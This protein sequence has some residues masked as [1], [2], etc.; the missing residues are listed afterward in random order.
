MTPAAAQ[1]A[2]ADILVIGRAITE[3]TNAGDA[4]RA[5]MAD[6]NSSASSSQNGDA[7]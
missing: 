1:Q 5:I 6:L 4:A 2:G 7:S 3:A